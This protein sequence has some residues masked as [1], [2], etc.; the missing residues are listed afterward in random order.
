MLTRTLLAVV[1]L[2]FAASHSLAVDPPAGAP[3]ELVVYPAQV[4]LS[5]PRD[6]QRLVVLGVWADGR[7]F[8]LTR[9][10]TVS[11]ASAKVATVDRG[12]VRPAGDG[13]PSPKSGPAG[14]SD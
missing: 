9:T 7:K 8:D 3:K 14:V 11:T 13:T 6:E 4:K 12:V 10:A 1:A 5:G 2:A